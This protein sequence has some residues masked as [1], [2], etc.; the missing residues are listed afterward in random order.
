MSVIKANGTQCPLREDHVTPGVHLASTSAPGQLATVIERR[1][2][3]IESS[4]SMRTHQSVLPPDSVMIVEL[5][6]PRLL[7]GEFRYQVLSEDSECETQAVEHSVTR[8]SNDCAVIVFRNN[9]HVEKKVI[10]LWL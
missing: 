3:S 8:V 1:V 4:P 10:I 9:S 5:P 7:N 6:K 2:R